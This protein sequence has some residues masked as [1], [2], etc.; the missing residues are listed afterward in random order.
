[1]QGLLLL[2]AAAFYMLQT[3]GVLAGA[4]DT[5]IKAPLQVCERALPSW[6]GTS[7]QS[8]M[9]AGLGWAGLEVHKVLLL[10]SLPLSAPLET[11]LPSH[12]SSMR[13][14]RWPRQ[15]RSDCRA[16]PACLPR[17]PCSAAPPRCTQRR[18][19]RWGASW[20]RADLARCAQQL[21][22]RHVLR[23]GAQQPLQRHVQRTGR[24]LEPPSAAPNLLWLVVWLHA[25]LMPC[26]ASSTWGWP[27]QHAGCKRPGLRHHLLLAVQVYRA[28]LNDPDGVEEP[29]DVLV[30]KA[31]E[32]GEAEVCLGRMPSSG[33]VPAVHGEA[34]RCSKGFVAAEAA[35]KLW[36]FLPAAHG[37]AACGCRRQRKARRR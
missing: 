36:L 7:Q 33:W 14:P 29:R 22:R 10:V 27:H 5:Y 25:G 20:R 21:L 18:T 17:L 31:T 34:E 26:S 1:M 8:C 9:F 4:I 35:W 23:T 16:H 3:P 11:R 13:L 32:F 12:A 19:L 15:R 28:V 2:A 37:E 6:R 30:K 24:T